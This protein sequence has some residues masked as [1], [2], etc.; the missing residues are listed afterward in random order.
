MVAGMDCLQP[1]RL[2]LLAMLA[3]CASTEQVIEPNA[4]PLP[5]VPVEIQAEPLHEPWLAWDLSARLVFER[6][7]HDLQ[8]GPAPEWNAEALT[9]LRA[10]LDEPGARATRAAVLLAHDLGDAAGECLLARLEQRHVAPSRGLDAGDIV[11]A[12]SLGRRALDHKQVQ[13]LLALVL[14][15]EPHPDLEI[16]VEC[17]ASALASGA[18]AAAP[19]LLRVLRTETPAQAQDL[20]DWERVT[21]L[22]WAKGRAAAALAAHT[23]L[24]HGFRADGS[25]A[26]QMQ[27]AN[28][29]ARALGLPEF[30]G[31]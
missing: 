4:Q 1:A 18:E 27:S 7:V 14:P 20:R 21:T 3:A 10:A 12:A 31:R 5:G 30:D 19:F 26:H 23:G 25:W 29:Y 11:A 13:R 15:G 8:A 9:A 6:R 16:R 24:V 2:L 28:L 17:A 22:A